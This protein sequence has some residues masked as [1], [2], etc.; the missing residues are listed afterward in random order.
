MAISPFTKPGTIVAVFEEIQQF[1]IHPSIR[2]YPRVGEPLVLQ[3]FVV[4]PFM[5]HMVYATVREYSPHLLIDINVLKVLEL[6]KQITEIL[7]KADKPIDG[8]SPELENVDG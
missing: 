6:P 4:L 1:E 5:P 3:S 8:V 2:E 7:D